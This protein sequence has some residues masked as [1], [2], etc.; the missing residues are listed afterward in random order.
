MADPA[1]KQKDLS[2]EA[3]TA[4]STAWDLGRVRTVHRRAELSML[5]TEPDCLQKEGKWKG[6][7]E[8]LLLLEK[9]ARNV[10]VHMTLC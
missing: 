5:S 6:A 3:Q 2:A 1:K 7:V 10:R 8:S 4:I 9:Q